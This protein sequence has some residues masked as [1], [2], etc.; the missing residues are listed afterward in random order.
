[1]LLAWALG[2]LFTFSTFVPVLVTGCMVVYGCISIVC[3]P[4]EW[5]GDAFKIDVVRVNFK[6]VCWYL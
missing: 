1:M 2:S 5:C 6:A 3:L 4:W